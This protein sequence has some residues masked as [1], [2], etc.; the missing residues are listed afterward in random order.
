V[1]DPSV[2]QRSTKGIKAKRASP[3][4]RPST[5]KRR[6]KS[7]LRFWPIAGLIG[8]LIALALAFLFL[9]RPSYDLQS[10]LNQR[11]DLIDK[12]IYSR[13]FKL[14]FSDKDVLSRQSLP[15]RSGDLSWK[16]SS[17]EL[18]LSERTPFSQVKRQMERDLTHVERDVS[19]RFT[20]DPSQP[21]KIEVL[22]GDLL[23]H[24]LIFRPPKVRV[25]EKK[26]GPRVAII[27]DDMGSNKRRARELINLEAP[28]T[29][30][31]FP[32][33]RNSRKL[34]QEAQEKGKE[35][36]LHMPMEPK[37]FPEINPGK[38]ALL[39]SMT[40]EELHRQIRENLE[41]IPFVKG[42]NNH[43]GSR[44]ME[45]K[46]RVG[47]LMEELKARELFFLDSRTTPNTVG[48]RTAKE[49]GIKTG[50]RNVF[51]DNNRYD[52]AD[53]RENIS[54]LLEIAKDEGK[55][56]GIG[57]PHPSTIR[58]LREMIPR[59]RESGIEIVHLSE[60]LE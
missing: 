28:L 56:I 55:A 3:R 16:I 43:M 19:L 45:D 48:Y 41:T 36:I 15:T 7:A 32:F 59:L 26:I 1:R 39:M 2:A 44:F 37:E 4:K 8:F 49:F 38:G 46:H 52:E 14:G 47:I 31:F 57:H 6:K 40:E 11:I 20:E 17:I 58:S 42:V 24:N 60:L 22:V 54:K 53:I 30:S 12:A 25:P 5:R 50:E 34:A 51:L 9:Y 18:Q 29:L 23:T 13:L 27:I 10:V 21:K 33:A 35:V